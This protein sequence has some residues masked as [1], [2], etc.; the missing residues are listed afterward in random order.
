MM[1]MIIG[2]IKINNELL[3]LSKE[4]KH[5]KCPLLKRRPRL[6]KVV[7]VYKRKSISIMDN[8]QLM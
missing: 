8:S 2:D 1:M 4:V 7:N 6:L 3:M 5:I